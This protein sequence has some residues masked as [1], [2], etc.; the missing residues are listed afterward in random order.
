MSDSENETL[1]F[2]KWNKARCLKYLREIDV[3]PTVKSLEKIRDLCAEEQDKRSKED[4]SSDSDDSQNS[5][6]SQDFAAVQDATTIQDAT[7]MQDAETL[8]DAADVVKIDEAIQ[9]TIAN[10]AIKN[11]VVKIAKIVVHAAQQRDPAWFR[12]YKREQEEERNKERAEWR[13]Q[14]EQLIKQKQEADQRWN[15]I[16]AVL[17]SP[18]AKQESL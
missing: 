10:D 9:S 14:N 5:D 18:L 8:L 15:K 6:N 2:S 16:V 3:F 11:A 12:R 4:A 13:A 7:T 17:T 1:D